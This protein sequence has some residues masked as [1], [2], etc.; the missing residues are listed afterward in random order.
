MRQAPPTRYRTLA[1][2]GL[3]SIEVREDQQQAASVAA[4]DLDVAGARLGQAEAELQRAQSEIEALAAQRDELRI[5]AARAGQVLVRRVDPGSVVQP[6]Q[7]LLELADPADRIV[8]ARFDQR[9]AG[10]LAV[11]D[12]V[13]VRARSLTSILLGRVERVELVADAVT[14]ERQARISLPAGVD[15]PLGE[16]VELQVA[17]QVTQVELAVPASALVVD[18]GRT[19]VWVV[20]D[21]S[22]QFA[23]VETGLHSADGWIE[24]VSGLEPGTSV[25]SYR[26]RP[27]REGQT[28][29]VREDPLP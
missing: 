29:D 8:L 13:Q 14:E 21:G 23:V 1:G 17:T 9:A 2:R 25:V 19:G 10:A 12:T 15:L 6:G 26:P 3:V 5:R 27:L 11:G 7:T 20:E 18:A 28:L 24:I 4:A 22:A 16:R